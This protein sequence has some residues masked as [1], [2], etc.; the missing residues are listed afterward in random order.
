MVEAGRLNYMT[1]CLNCHG[2]EG[3]GDGPLNELINMKPSDLTALAAANDGEFPEEWVD[4][5]IRGYDEE[6]LLAHGDREMPIWE[7]V[8]QEQAEGDNVVETVDTRVAEIIAYLKT[9]QG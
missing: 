4:G 1:Y 2:D 8:W 7:A 5:V 9:I 3:K 6:V